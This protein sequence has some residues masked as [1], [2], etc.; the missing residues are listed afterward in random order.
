MEIKSNLQN[1]LGPLDT[2]AATDTR[3]TEA[4]KSHAHGK[5]RLADDQPN[6]DADQVQLSASAS[7]EAARA[8]KI[9]ALEKAVAN[10][11]YHP[12]AKDIASS[13]VDTVILESREPK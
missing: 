3:R 6:L 7:Q 1:A 5:A 11:T 10:G 8:R 9:E 13:L 4:A 2:S 12:N